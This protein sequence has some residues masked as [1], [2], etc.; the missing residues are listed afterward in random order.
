[1]QTIIANND[2][3]ASSDC[4]GMMERFEGLAQFI[5]YCSAPMTVAVQG[6]WGSGKTTAMNIIRSLISEEQDGA[7]G[8]LTIW[9]NTW[10]FSVLGDREKL[11]LDLMYMVYKKLGDYIQELTPKEETDTEQTGW[12][13]KLKAVSGKVQDAKKAAKGLA[14]MIGQYAMKKSDEVEAIG[15]NFLEAFGSE[16]PKDPQKLLSES[17]GS[18]AASSNA[19][20]VM[21]LKS[22]I[23]Q[24]I[25]SLFELSGKKRLYFFIDDLDRLDP[26]IAV[27]LLEGMKNFLECDGCIFV[28]AI[29][30]TVIERGLRSKYGADFDI[31]NSDRASK[32]FD[33][34]IQVPFDLPVHN[35]NLDAYVGSLLEKSELA[36]QKDEFVRILKAFQEYN[37]R[38]IKRSFNLLELYHVMDGKL[39]PQSTDRNICC[40]Y[41]LVML[42]L[43]S[44]ADHDGLGAVLSALSVNDKDILLHFNEQVNESRELLASKHIAALMNALG[45]A[46]LH[47]SEA[48]DPARAAQTETLR[49]D[50]AG[51]EKLL[52]LAATFKETVKIIAEQQDY[53][54]TVLPNDIVRRLYRT[55]R[56]NLSEDAVLS[57]AWE[58]TETAEHSAQEYKLYVKSRQE[59]TPLMMVRWIV[60]TQV[61]LTVQKQ[62]ALTVDDLFRNVQEFFRL[63][64]T[65]GTERGAFDYY[66]NESNIVLSRMRYYAAGCPIDIMLKN[67]HILRENA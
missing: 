63:I 3:S 49:N 59:H 23:E 60:G 5:R 64:G 50:A 19:A 12:Q 65:G 55:L 25:R 39:H 34:I 17:L 28:L 52:V 57:G 38:T 13:G 35:Y 37:P 46:V 1:M 45:I 27:E 66:D 56:S 58:E 44:K 8:A 2:L 29:D 67:A 42:R 16:T 22:N 51:A 61:N 24:A 7:E 48:D 26:Q 62:N 4:L 40:R 9:F 20:F 10:Q 18:Y 11:I 14:L 21:N 33:K 30:Q 6:D 41:A 47:L 53:T 54:Q 36:E 32:F 43:R 15:E 31:R